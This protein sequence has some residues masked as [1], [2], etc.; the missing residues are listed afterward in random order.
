MLYLY[1]GKERVAFTGKSL[2]NT[3]RTALLSCSDTCPSSD[4]DTAWI[5]RTVVNLGINREANIRVDAILHMMYQVH[6][7]LW[8][9]FPVLADLI[10]AV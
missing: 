1:R 6:Q 3:F 7:D 4:L 10:Y 2:V 5:R 9:V 8:E